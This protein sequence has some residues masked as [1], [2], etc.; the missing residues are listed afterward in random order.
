MGQFGVR[1]INSGACDVEFNLNNNF[2]INFDYSLLNKSQASEIYMY[3]AGS[4]VTFSYTDCNGKNLSGS[5]KGVE[6]EHV[7]ARPFGAIRTA[8][9]R[10]RKYNSASLPW[11]RYA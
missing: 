3:P 2:N 9:R 8:R 7:F 4:E 11:G 6:G 1:V 10:Q 5:V